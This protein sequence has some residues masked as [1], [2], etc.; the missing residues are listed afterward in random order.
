ML[1]GSFKTDI[2]QPRSTRTRSLKRMRV[3]SDGSLE[4]YVVTQ[5]LYDNGTVGLYKDTTDAHFRKLRPS[6]LVSGSSSVQ[7]SDSSSVAGGGSSSLVART[8]LPPRG[9]PSRFSARVA[10]QP[11]PPV[12]EAPLTAKIVLNMGTVVQVQ[13]LKGVLVNKAIR[14]VLEMD[15][16]REQIKEIL[17]QPGMIASGPLCRAMRIRRA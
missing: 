7:S 3:K 4:E 12:T 13:S 2:A 14:T 6:R 1:S 11:V 8:V 5:V 15:G 17:K 16:G 10:S 9:A